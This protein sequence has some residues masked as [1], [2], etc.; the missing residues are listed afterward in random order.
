MKDH[1]KKAEEALERAAVPGDHNVQVLA[2]QY[3]KAQ[4]EATLA[5][6]VE[7]KTIREIMEGK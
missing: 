5:I 1:L 7:L 4:A 6:A 3:A 2:F